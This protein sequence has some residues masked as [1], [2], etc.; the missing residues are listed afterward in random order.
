MRQLHSFCCCFNKSLKSVVRFTLSACLNSDTHIPNAQQPHLVSGYHTG[1]C[2][3]RLSLNSVKIAKSGKE[4]VLGLSI[5]KTQQKKLRCIQQRGNIWESILLW[6][7][8]E[9]SEMC[10]VSYVKSWSKFRTE[11]ISVRFSHVEELG[12][13]NR[14]AAI[15]AGI[16]K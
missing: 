5:E 16:E 13:I 12:S 7:P 6:E 3:H 2:R 14:T 1:Q 11:K 8:R 4:Q 10:T 9:E 15:W